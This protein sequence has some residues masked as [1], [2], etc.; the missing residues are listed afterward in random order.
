[1]VTSTLPSAVPRAVAV[2]SSATAASLRLILL[3]LL[4]F[5]CRVGATP[6]FVFEPG[7]P[8]DEAA[9]AMQVKDI[10]R[11]L[12]SNE[13]GAVWD[14]ASTSLKQSTPRPAFIDGIKSLRDSVGELQSRTLKGV[15]FATDI[16]DSA[17]GR[18][19][20][21]FFESR[22]AQATVEE[23]VVLVMQDGQWRVTGYF[24]TKRFTIHGDAG[25]T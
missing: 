21:A 9:V 23:K 13:T 19:A 17:P 11:L 12:D 20:A 8:Q 3:V 1:M 15:G 7:S 14:G 5:S 4:C 18:Y 22:F 10:L 25:K 6:A 2:S 16:P 24:I